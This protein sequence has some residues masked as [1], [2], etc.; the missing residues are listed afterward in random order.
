MKHVKVNYHFIR[1]RVAKGLLDF[2]F[3]SMHD[4]VKNNLNLI[5]L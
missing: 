5:K 1:E 3:I 2:W 4:Q